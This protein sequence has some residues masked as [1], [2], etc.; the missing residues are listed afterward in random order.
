[1]RFVAVAAG[2]AVVTMVFGFVVLMI[3]GI[4]G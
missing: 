4:V 1:L 2:V 3:V